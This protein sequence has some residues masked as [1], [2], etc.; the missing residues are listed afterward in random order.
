MRPLF[1]GSHPAIDFLNT[2]LAPDGEPIETIGDGKTYLDWF[3]AAGLLDEARAS[4]L[5][6]RFGTKA[7]DAAAVEARKVRD[8]AR[9]WLA[10]W[11][12]KPRGDYEAEIATLNKLLAR[13]ALSR[14]VVVTSEGL[15]VVEV[16]HIETAEALIALVAVQFAALITEEEASLVKSC[17]GSACTL[18]FLDRTKAHRRLFCS[19][20]GCGNRAKVAAFRERQRG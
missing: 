1:I 16:P 11:R 14:E 20:A 6:R 13:E 12:A 7:L 2:A 18:W 9:E 8:W 19:A 10:V 15:E 3:V 5:A 4:K 17:A